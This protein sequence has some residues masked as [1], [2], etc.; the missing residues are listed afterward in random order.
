MVWGMEETMVWGI[1]ISTDGWAGLRAALEAWT[2][3]ALMDALADDAFERVEQASGSTEHASRAAEAFRAR[4]ANAP[5]DALAHQAYEALERNDTCDNGGHLYWIDRE[6][7][8][9]CLNER[10]II[11]VWQTSTLG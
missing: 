4:V 1:S 2:R 11:F 8:H 3:E 10:N 5:Q 7:C 9:I 6:G